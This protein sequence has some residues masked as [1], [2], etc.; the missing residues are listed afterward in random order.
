MDAAVTELAV[1]EVRLLGTFTGQLRHTSHRLTV[2]LALLDLILKHLCHILM[3]MQIVID[4]L[5][6]EITH[7]FINAHPIW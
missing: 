2:A 6:D 5:L 7:I 4:L 1:M 3:D